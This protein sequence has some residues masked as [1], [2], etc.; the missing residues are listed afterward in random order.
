M[1]DKLLSGGASKN[2]ITAKQTKPKIPT[3]RPIIK[4]MFNELETSKL[5]LLE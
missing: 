2:P 5:E 4:L 1:S 3:Q